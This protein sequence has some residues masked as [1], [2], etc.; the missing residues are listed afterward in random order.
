MQSLRICRHCSVPISG[1][2]DKKFCSPNCR[3]RFSEGTQ[4][5]FESREKKKRNYVLFDSAARLAKIYVQY[6]P[7]ERLGLIQSYIL[8]AR[9]GNTK[10]REILSNHYLMKPDNDYGNPYKGSR[11]RSFGSLAAACERYCRYYWNASAAD[12]VYN[13]ADEPDDGVID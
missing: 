5:S 11:G 12:V 8:M 9:E 6:S 13:R 4:N 1:R 7:F 3:K 2:S 10:M